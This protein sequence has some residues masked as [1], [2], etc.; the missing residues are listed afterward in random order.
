MKQD[1]CWLLLDAGN[2]RIKWG[3]AD[4]GGLTETGWLDNHKDHAALQTEWQRHTPPDRVWLATSVSGQYREE[5]KSVIE[6][7]WRI[8][9]EVVQTAPRFGG[10]KN[11]YHQYQQLGVDRWL[12]LIAAWRVAQRPLCLVDC[13]TAITIDV[14]DATGRHQG[15]VILPGFGHSA[16]TLLSAAPHLKQDSLTEEGGPLL[17]RGTAEGLRLQNDGSV[18]RVDEMLGKIIQHYGAL[19]LLVTGG[20]RSVLREASVYS[21]KEMQ[22]LVL[23]GLLLVAKGEGVHSPSA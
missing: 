10:L 14:V 17:G 2:S 5:I 22:H 6:S 1:A 21:M 16:E 3:W 13:G 11:G 4:Q 19:E 15:G 7:L 18:A 23:E 9:V 8:D 12:G 20:D